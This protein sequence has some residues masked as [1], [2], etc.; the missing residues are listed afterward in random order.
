MGKGKGKVI[1]KV[2]PKGGSEAKKIVSKPM[3]QQVIV[4][5]KVGK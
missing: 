3:S 1:V 2:E 4:R 5:R